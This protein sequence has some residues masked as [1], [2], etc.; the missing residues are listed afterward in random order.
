MQ[1]I[2]K[3]EGTGEL[4]IKAHLIGHEGVAKG[5]VGDGVD[6]DEIGFVASEDSVIGVVRI[7]HKAEVVAAFDV[8]RGRFELAVDL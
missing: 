5:L 8:V 1:L 2:K 4:P 6:A 3:A 7:G